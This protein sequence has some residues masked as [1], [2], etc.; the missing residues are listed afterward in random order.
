MTNEKQKKSVTQNTN[1]GF[2]VHHP[3]AKN[4]ADANQKTKKS[5]DLHDPRYIHVPGS[6]RVYDRNKLLAVLLVPLLMTLMQVSSVNNILAVIQDAIGASNSD[7]QWVLAGYSLAIGIVLVPAGRLGDIYGRST[8]FVI[9]LSIFSIT[10]LLV[11]LAN[12]PLMLNIMRLFQGF[13]SGMLSP[14]TT[15]LIQQ[16]FDGRARAKAFSLFGL[17]VSISVAIGPILSGELIALF[18]SELGWRLSFAVNMPI[19]LIGVILALRWLPFGKERRTVGKNKDAIQLEYEAQQIAEKK[20]PYPRRQHEKIDIDPFGM[21]L[22]AVAVLGVMLP[23]VT[24]APAWKW[25]IVGLGFLLLTLW[26]VWEKSY[27]ARGKFPMV[28]LQLFKIRTFAYSMSI[29]TIQF[30]GTTSTFAILAIFLHDSLG[31]DALH[32]GLVTLFDAIASGIAAVVAGRYAYEHGRGMQVFSLAMITTGLLGS[33]VT[34]WLIYLGFSYWWLI[35]PLMVMG[36]GQGTMGASNQTQSMLDVP[37]SHGGT[38]GG[39]IQT[40]QRM[41]TAIGNALVTAV[42]FAVQANPKFGEISGY[43]SI[44]ISFALISIITIIAMVVAIFFWREKYA[45]ANTADKA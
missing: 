38:A 27:A 18:G 13:G 33:I 34:V 43:F 10:S 41:A 3:Q 22:L 42:F 7:I 35:I 17:V 40:G 26:V 14:Q 9:G 8:M 25:A 1:K 15:G 6:N 31:I 20:Q 21:I 12:D 4:A 45:R 5:K 29:V 32:V 39:V 11:G 24:E 28:D 16:Y 23:F 44:S 37:A 30:L 36:T 2:T 19:G